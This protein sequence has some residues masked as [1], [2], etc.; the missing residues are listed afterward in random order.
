MCKETDCDRIVVFDIPGTNGGGLT[1]G[2]NIFLRGGGEPDYRQSLLA[3]E[4]MH[5]VQFTALLNVVAERYGG[6][7][8]LA[9]PEAMT[10]WAVGMSPS[11]WHNLRNHD[12]YSYDRST[13]FNA[14]TLEQQGEVVGNC[15]GYLDDCDISPFRP[16]WMDGR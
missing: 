10:V 11:L 6:S 8:T 13:P 4:V 2:Y 14:M 16:F 7:T 3:H 9:W 5:T 15:L 1:W 12:I